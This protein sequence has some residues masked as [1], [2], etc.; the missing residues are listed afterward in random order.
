MLCLQTQ[1]RIVKVPVTIVS[2]LFLLDLDGYKPFLEY[3]KKRLFLSL[4][5]SSL[6]KSYEYLFIITPSRI[7]L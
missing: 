1:Q 6:D 3:T 7:I 5:L 4:S 2:K